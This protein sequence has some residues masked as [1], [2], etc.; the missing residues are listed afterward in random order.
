MENQKLTQEEL[1]TLTQLQEKSRAI[2]QEFGEISIIRLGVEEREANAKTYLTELRKAER[3]FG[4]E[5]SDKYG[6]GTINLAE[7]EFIPTPAAE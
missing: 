7:G 4:K 2:T 6:N 1:Q 5:L 3:D